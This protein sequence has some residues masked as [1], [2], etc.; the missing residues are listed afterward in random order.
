PMVHCLVLSVTFTPNVEVSTNGVRLNERLEQE[1][2]VTPRSL[3][4]T[5]PLVPVMGLLP[6]RIIVPAPSLAHVLVGVWPLMVPEKVTVLSWSTIQ[7]LV[8][9]AIGLKVKLFAT[10]PPPLRPV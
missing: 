5:T 7:R 1:P 10:T 2:P 3:P 9:P 6:E 8:R 4:P